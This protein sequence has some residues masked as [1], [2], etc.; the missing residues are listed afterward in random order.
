MSFQQVIKSGSDS[1]VADVSAAK[2]LKV[3]VAQVTT[4]E[5]V[6]AATEVGAFRMFSEN[7]PGTKTGTPYLYSPETDD[8]FRLRTALDVILDNEI[9]NYVAQNTKKHVYRNTTMTLGWTAAGLQTNATGITTTTTGASFQTY[10]TFPILGTASAY[11]ESRMAFSALPV[12]NSFVDFGGGLLNTTNPFAP[13]DG[14]YFRVS[15]AGVNIVVNINGTETETLLD[16]TYTANTKYTFI[17]SI[18]QGEVKAWIDN[19]LYAHIDI[20]TAQNQP[21]MSASLPFFI[22]HAIVGGAAGGVLQATCSYYSVTVGGV[23][24]ADRLSAQGNRMHGSHQGLSGGT[25]GSLAN[26]ANSA[27][28]TAAVPTNTTAALGS[29]L[30]GQ[31]WET[32]TLAVTTDGIIDSYQVPAASVN[33]NQKRLAIRGVRISSFIQTALTGGGYVASWSLAF[34]HTAVSLGTAEA[35]TTKAPVRVP[36]G[37]Q[38]VASGA[39]ALVKLDAIAIDFEMPIFVN[40]GEFVA[41]VKKKVGTAPS[42]GVVGH[43][44]T[45]DYGWE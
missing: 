13:A 5:G 16:F 19:V 22:R 7:D 37:I 25:M 42:A 23:V 28:P 29:G 21:I 33:G 1:N 30:G 14:V 6:D 44:I 4:V 34:G 45:F 27:N 35:A 10:A 39:L 15:S 11:F 2:R 24:A 36:L 9:F 18:N 8:D 26:Y 43:V 32:D 20:R 3:D 31:F 38:S 41:V 40:P 12:A 17:V